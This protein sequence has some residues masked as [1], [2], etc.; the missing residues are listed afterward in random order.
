MNA[1]LPRSVGELAGP[2]LL[3]GTGALLAV[4]LFAADGSAYGP[5]VWIGGAAVV[6]GSAALVLA[7]LGVLMWPSLDRS[8]LAF[9][10]LLGGFVLWTGLSVLWSYTPD[11]SWEYLNRELVYLAF[12]VLGLFVGALGGR[13]VPVVGAGLAGLI[14]AALLWALA[15]KVVPNLFPDGERIARLRD[16]IG[17]WNGLA[18][19]A[20]MALPLGLWGA[21]RGEHRRIV[22]VASALLLF[23]AMIALLLTY[24]RGGAVV[25]LV[26]VAVYLT[27]TTERVEAIAALAIAG[28][29]AIA[30]SAW[31]FQEPGLVDDLQTYDDRLHAGVIFGVLVVV[32]CAL[33]AGVA[34]LAVLREAEWRPR[35]RW[36]VTG[37]R[38]AA[39]AAVL[40][41]VAVVAASG[42]H[43]VGWLRDGFREFT[44]PV[45]AAGSAPGRL[46]SFSSNSRWTWWKEAWHLFEDEPLDGTGAATFAIARRPIRENTTFATEPHN[47][48]LQFLSETGLV[49][50]LL[51][52]G[53]TV[54]AFLGVLAAIRRLA[55][56]ESAAATALAIAAL[57]YLLH[58][59][60]DYDWNFLALTA[61]LL[62]VLG[63]LLAAGL[64]PQRRSRSILWAAATVVAATAVVFS[65]AAPWLA[66]RRVDAAFAALRRDDPQTALDRAESAHSL[67][68]LSIEPLLAIAAADEAAGRNREALERYV[69]AVELQPKSWR[70]WYE[71]GQFELDKGNRDSGILHLQRARDLDPLGPANDLL[72]QLGL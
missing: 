8:G 5:V 34:Y 12:L 27:V 21:V 61:P 24:S 39:G 68:P 33:V 70:S 11:A 62:V 57:A 56:D 1:G 16:P 19:L 13:V 15:G 54:A 71:L 18:L 43:P 36:E 72:L 37:A 3:G 25:A 29:P 23:V 26:A 20:A 46:G 45:S 2:V 48:G 30:I 4:A 42:G 60:V 65:L 44:N 52:G 67:N 17:Y 64:P 41:V 6:L 50:F 55:G 49:G 47:L 59:L 9:V 14:G 51:A 31:G 40:F 32:G 53:A 58:A 66:S 7:W 35:F 22:R 38:L 10:G 69:Q 28:L 63:V